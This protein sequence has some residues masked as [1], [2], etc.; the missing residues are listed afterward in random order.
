MRQRPLFWLTA[1]LLG[2]AVGIIVWQHTARQ[3]RAAEAA[4]ILARDESSSVS[5]ADPAK[6]AIAV[7]S[8]QTNAAA[9]KS[10]YP[11]RLSNTSKKLDQLLKD[12]H[13]IIL[14][15]ALIDTARPL[16]LA[17]P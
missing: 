13:A 17:I 2:L 14:V 6:P 3:R 1:S 9:K 11:Y 16:N 4:R 10:R 15:N 7:A 5:P 8:V 12:D